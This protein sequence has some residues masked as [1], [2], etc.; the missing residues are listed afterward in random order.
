MCDGKTQASSQNPVSTRLYP[1]LPRPS[2][3][4]WASSQE[5]DPPNSKSSKR[6]P[7]RPRPTA[8]ASRCPRRSGPWAGTGGALPG[9]CSRPRRVGLRGE[10]H[11]S[12]PAQATAPLRQRLLRPLAPLRSPVFAGGLDVVGPVGMGELLLPEEAGRADAVLRLVLVVLV[13]VGHFGGGP[14]LPARSELC[15]RA[16]PPA[17]RQLV[18]DSCCGPLC[19]SPCRPSAPLRTRERAAPAS[20]RGEVGPDQGPHVFAAPLGP[21]GLFVLGLL[22]VVVSLA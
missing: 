1:T 8:L 7:R 9:A 2:R 19:A 20:W 10:R 15:R 18:S 11:K 3:P 12:P 4:S 22:S 21:V 6:T 16:W 14:D 5:A 13:V 17:R